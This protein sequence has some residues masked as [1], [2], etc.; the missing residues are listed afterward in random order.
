M[1]TLLVSFLAQ[2]TVQYSTSYGRYCLI[3]PN[4]WYVEYEKIIHESG[5]LTRR[6]LKQI[7]RQLLDY[8]AYMYVN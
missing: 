6:A 1:L 8:W 7:E 5:A 4:M 3:S 2:T